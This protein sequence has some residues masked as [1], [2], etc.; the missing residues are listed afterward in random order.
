MLPKSI[1]ESFL[2]ENTGCGDKVSG[3]EEDCNISACGECASADGCNTSANGNCSHAEGCGSKALG[4]CSHAEGSNT[5][6]LETNSHSE[7]C[8]TR[9]LGNCS[10]A[11]GSNTSAYSDASH[12]EGVNTKTRGNYAHAEGNNNEANGESSHAQGIGTK[13]EGYASFSSG[14]YTTVRGSYSHAE[15]YST[16]VNGSYSHAEG[17]SSTVNGSYSHAEGI[18]TTANG[19]YSHAE[20][21]STLT[22]GYGSH[23]EGISTYARA[24]YSHSEG[25][26]TDTKANAGSHIMGIYGDADTPYSWFLGGGTYDTRAL[27]AK[28]LYTGDGY[29][30]NAWHAGGTG[31]AEVYRSLS[32]Q[33]MDPGYFVTLDGEFIRTA[34]DLD[35]FVLGVTSVNPGFISNSSEL[36]LGNSLLTGTWKEVLYEDVPIAEKMDNDGNITEPAQII[37]QPLLKTQAAAA[38]PGQ[39]A[40]ICSASGGTLVT[41]LGQV[42]VT[43]DGTCVVNGYCLPNKDGIATAS[44]TGYKVMKRISDNQI[45]I[46]FR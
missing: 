14:G 34:N 22:E 7:G 41:L 18:Y 28:I 39:T 36:S 33:P 43:D 10:H 37:K 19:S 24:P 42:L 11:E 29:I 6:A 8:N 2:D 25:Y 9:A 27:A 32:G 26:Y 3:T 31:Y 1:N 45:L 21:N 12:T 15:G 4:D 20:G 23:A 38:A 17:Y 35:L 30:R 13:S 40:A 44:P 16:T 46:F 5:R